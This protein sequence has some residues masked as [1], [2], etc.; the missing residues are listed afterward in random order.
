LNFFEN[1][2]QPRKISDGRVIDGKYRPANQ[3]GEKI[4]ENVKSIR[5]RSAFV[6]KKNLL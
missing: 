6:Q 5:K 2:A 3:T 1:S 4:L